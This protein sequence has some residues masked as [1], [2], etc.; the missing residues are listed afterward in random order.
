MPISHEFDYVKPATLAEALAAL[1]GAGGDAE[2]LAG[3]TDLVAWLRDGAARPELVIDLKGIDGLSDISVDDGVLSM[4]ALATFADVIES[5]VAAEALPVL[6]EMAGTMG[7]T[8]VRNRATLAGNICS[9]VPSCDS[10]P[11]LLVCEAEVGVA[12]PRDGRVVPVTEWFRGPG[13]TALGASEIVVGIR[14]PVPPSGHG[15]CY[16]KLRRTRGEDLAQAGVAAL[17]LPGGVYRVAFGAV[18][19]TPVRARRIEELLAGKSL[20]DDVI[21]RAKKLVADET[22]PIADIRA[23]REYRAHML[24]VMLERC[25]R[26]AAARRDGSGPPYG[27]QLI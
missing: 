8:G 26:A 18:A 23:S 17:A 9:A 11:V 1:E 25:L 19:P 4:G 2:L 12:G 24:P 21:A 15:A 7:S 10:G 14:V 6:G 20:D 3:G 16:V 13:K 5:E 22:S 27:T